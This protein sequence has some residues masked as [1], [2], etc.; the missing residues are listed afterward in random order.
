MQSKNAA[1][2]AGKN[3]SGSILQQNLW[4]G[5]PWDA[6]LQKGVPGGQVHDF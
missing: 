1:S 3:N 6:F 2:M 4:K 5:K